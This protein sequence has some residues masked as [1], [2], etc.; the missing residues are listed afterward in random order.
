MATLLFLATIQTRADVNIGEAAAA[1]GVTAKMIRHYEAIGLLPPASRSHSGYRRYD[2]SD[3]HTLRFVRRAR[4]LG[5]SIETIGRLLAL[6][7][8][9]DRAS[10]DIKRVAL[11][12]LAELDRKIVELQAMRGALARLA[13]LCHGDRRP[14]CP[15]LDDLAAGGRPSRSPRTGAT[16]SRSP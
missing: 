1:T 8:D 11:E 16:L 10:A 15:I 6:W 4:D 14:E 5:F 13:R 2:D 9:R 3:V 7:H 12:H